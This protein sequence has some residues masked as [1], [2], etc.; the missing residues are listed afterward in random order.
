MGILRGVALTYV[1]HDHGH[2][3]GSIVPVASPCV[4]VIVEAV[5][6]AAVG[7]TQN[8]W[9]ATPNFVGGNQWKVYGCGSSLVIGPCCGGSQ[10]GD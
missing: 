1:L 5:L 3:V 4:V 10:S 6:A 8:C 7:K 9:A 2:I